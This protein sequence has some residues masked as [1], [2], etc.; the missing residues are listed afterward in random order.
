MLAGLRR[1]GR[2]TS[3]HFGALCKGNITSK[4]EA[5]ISSGRLDS[6]QP[7]AAIQWG[8]MHE[9]TAYKFYQSTSPHGNYVRKAGIFIANVGFLASSPDGVVFDSEGDTLIGIIEIKC[10]YSCRGNTVR[11]GCKNLKSFFCQLNESNLVVLKR[12]HQYYFQVQGAMAITGAQWCDF[13]VWT[14]KE[15]TIERIAFDP[16]FWESTYAYLRNVYYCYILPELI[17]P[18]LHLGLE[19]MH[20]DTFNQ[21]NSIF[22]Q[23]QQHEE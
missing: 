14:P 4:V 1:F 21:T 10:P 2:I 19:I 8:I 22:N 6:K 20:Y 3:S 17:Y 16:K 23:E 9:D 18:R 7:A 5:V 12:N 13:I 11:D 15:C